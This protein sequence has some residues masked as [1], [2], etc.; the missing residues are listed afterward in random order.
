FQEEFDAEKSEAEV[1]QQYALFPVWY[2][3]SINPRNNEKGAAFDGKEH[4][5]DAKKP[6]SKV[7]L[8]PSSSA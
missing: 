1:D 3:S 5:F 4:D 7:I 6:M 2:S 8:S